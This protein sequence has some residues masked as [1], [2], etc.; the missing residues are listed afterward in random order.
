M[1]PFPKRLHGHFVLV[2]QRLCAFLGAQILTSGPVRLPPL[3]APKRKRK[4]Q[5]GGKHTHT[6]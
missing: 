3:F 4:G 6:Q 1:N 2:L 5:A